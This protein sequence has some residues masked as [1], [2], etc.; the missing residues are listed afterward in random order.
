MNSPGD[1][2]TSIMLLRIKELEWEV[3]FQERLI[4]QTRLLETIK[5][6]VSG[7]TDY[8]MNVSNTVKILKNFS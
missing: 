2:V 1:F 6:F 3:F 4:F 7:N 5:S 8:P